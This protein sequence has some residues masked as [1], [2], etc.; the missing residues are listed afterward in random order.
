MGHF[1]Y[2]FK[3][4]KL[5]FDLTT[6]VKS[7]DGTNLSAFYK[8]L[9]TLVLSMAIGAIDSQFE[10]K[11]QKKRLA[12][13]F[14]ASLKNVKNPKAKE[15]LVRSFAI[16]SNFVVDG[17]VAKKSIATMMMMI[18]PQHGDE[19][20][21]KDKSRSDTS[22]ESES[23]EEEEEKFENLASHIPEDAWNGIF[24][25]LPN[26]RD[27][28][29]AGQVQK[30]WYRLVKA[31][32][33]S[34]FPFLLMQSNELMKSFVD[35]E[36]LVTGSLDLSYNDEIT[37]A[38]LSK[39]VH[40]TKVSL[41]GN[42]TIKKAGLSPLKNLRVLKGESVIT[43]DLLSDLP[44]LVKLSLLGSPVTGDSFPSL[45]K[46]ASLC[47]HH[48]GAPR[49]ATDKL[50]LLTNLTDLGYHDDKAFSSA[51]LAWEM[52]SLKTLVCSSKW[53]PISIKG[54]TGLTKLEASG[55][56]KITDRE[57][58]RLTNLTYLN[59][60]VGDDDEEEDEDEEGGE[61]TEASI[62][63]ITGLKTLM[64]EGRTGISGRAF[65]DLPDLEFLR[66]AHCGDSFT[67][68]HLAACGSLTSLDMVNTL[69]IDESFLEISQAKLV[70]LNAM[71][72]DISLQNT[73]AF[74]NLTSLSV[75][76][77][78]VAL[79]DIA[80]LTNLT[81]LT[82]TEAVEAYRFVGKRFKYA[83]KFADK[84]NLHLWGRLSN[85]KSLFLSAQSSTRGKLLERTFVN[86][87]IINDILIL[88]GSQGRLTKLSIS[89]S[90]TVTDETI[91]TLSSLTSLSVAACDRITSRSIGK[92]ENLRRLFWAPPRE[93][94]DS[95][96]GN[97]K[98]KYLS[99]LPLCNLY[100]LVSL[101]IVSY[102]YVNRR[103]E[104]EKRIMCQKLL[105]LN[106]T[107]RQLLAPIVKDRR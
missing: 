46:L 20:E 98:M 15:S 76:Y 99:Y 75:S 16:V 73:N 97:W 30:S 71:W 103:I 61:I 83:E 21:E 53:D 11:E 70:S 63:K 58:K 105:K 12:R 51:P 45:T 9:E 40:L 4:R 77:R 101:R 62:S 29:M 48:Q 72:S 100:N 37:N 84:N 85:L 82:I 31:I 36:N 87:P 44:N 23:D 74:I 60:D 7:T 49:L 27:L 13:D 65:R 67:D 89:S 33:A 14:F 28:L 91:S 35:V 55:K 64:I 26:M 42:F 41:Y 90:D 79:E 43:D 17:G 88:V 2:L 38:T 10:R 1:S 81:E 47:V 96:P 39:F 68:R 22:S 107:S 94:D 24:A 34:H 32:I 52:K 5:L 54:L 19:G 106:G 50:I 69:G 6:E 25:F 95:A 78:D 102:Y 59:I 8:I 18:G 56:C 92:L 57:L 80:K 66:I 93:E 3:G 86:D 104:G